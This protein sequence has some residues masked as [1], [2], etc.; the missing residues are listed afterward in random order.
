MKFSEYSRLE[1]IG[2]IGIAVLSLI[3]I[4]IAVLGYSAAYT[5]PFFLPWFVFLM[6]GR[7]SRKRKK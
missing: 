1:R 7:S 3:S 2:M 6:I 5:T 4:L